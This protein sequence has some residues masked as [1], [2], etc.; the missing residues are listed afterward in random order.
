MRV[1]FMKIIVVEMFFCRYGKPHNELER[2]KIVILP[3]TLKSMLFEIFASGRFLKGIGRK[4]KFL[5]FLILIF[6]VIVQ[7]FKHT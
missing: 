1:F 5:K 2:R 7:S 4:K 3:Q 6:E